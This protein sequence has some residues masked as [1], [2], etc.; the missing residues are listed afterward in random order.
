MAM[1]VKIALKVGLALTFKAIGGNSDNNG[2]KNSNTSGLGLD[3]ALICLLV[4]LNSRNHERRQ[5][6]GQK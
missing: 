4:L 6:R 5:F 1:E 2:S 3:M